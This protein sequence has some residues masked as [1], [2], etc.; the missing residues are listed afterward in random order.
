[1]VVHPNMKRNANKKTIFSFC[2]QIL[3]LNIGE[4]FRLTVR[5]Q[6]NTTDITSSIYKNYLASSIFVSHRL[7]QNS[8]ALALTDL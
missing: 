2:I 4:V 6:P 5:R 8:Y 1:M 3:H 7:Q